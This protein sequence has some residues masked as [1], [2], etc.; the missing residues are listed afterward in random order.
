MSETPEG[1]SVEL[2]VAINR[3]SDRVDTLS[4][5]GT[6]QTV[7]LSGGSFGV[8][9]SA[10]A[11]AICFL[12]FCVILVLFIGH[13]RKIERMQDHLNAIYMMA[14]QLQPEKKDQ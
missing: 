2:I 14:P 1:A 8:W 5:Q 10:F 7:T 4:R 9:I 11:A 3:F 13:D 12:M 6:N